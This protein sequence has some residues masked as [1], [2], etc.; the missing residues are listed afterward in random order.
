[1]ELIGV[2]YTSPEVAQE[3][4]KEWF[5]EIITPEIERNTDVQGS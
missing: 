4:A 3:R 2:G 1:M 5:S